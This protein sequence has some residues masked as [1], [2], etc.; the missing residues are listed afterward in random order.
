M[1]FAKYLEIQQDDEVSFEGIDDQVLSFFSEID[2]RSI[3]TKEGVLVYM[4]KKKT[5]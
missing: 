3:K 1:G 5:V 4:E 2:R